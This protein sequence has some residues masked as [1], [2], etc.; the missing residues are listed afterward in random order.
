MII[1]EQ[2]RAFLAELAD[3]TLSMRGGTLRGSDDDE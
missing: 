3:S 2:N 1:V